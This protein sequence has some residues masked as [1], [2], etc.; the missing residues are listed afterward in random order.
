MSFR[1]ARVLGVCGAVGAT[2]VGLT[3]LGASVRGG[4]TLYVL[5]LVSLG[6]GGVVAAI[7][8]WRWEPHDVDAEALI[9]LALASAALENADPAA[10][11]YAAS[12]AVASAGTSRTRNRALTTLAWAA[13]GQGYPER[14]KVVLDSIQPCH[15]LDVSCLA[16]VECARGNTELAIQALELARTL[17]SLTCDGAKLLVDCHLRA[18]GIERAVLSA[19]Q[20][21]RV[22]GT[23]NCEQVLEAARLAGA[24]RAAASLAA[25]IRKETA[26]LPPVGAPAG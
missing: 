9:Q 8:R 18:N 11:A 14:A 24:T 22:L 12:K 25:L 17:G 3:A 23:A 10:A 13:L 5:G 26:A 2:L 7:A 6:V 20:N 15:E 16:A 1:T 21:W 4:A 19:M